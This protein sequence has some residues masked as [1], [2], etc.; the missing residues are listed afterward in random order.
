[1]VGD[2]VQLVDDEDLAGGIDDDTGVH[3][4]HQVR[5]RDNLEKRRVQAAD[6]PGFLVEEL[7]RPG[8]WEKT[9]RALRREGVTQYY[10]VGAGQAL[11]KFK[12]WIDIEL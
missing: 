4:E 12:R 5:L 3:V 1:V 2:R 7:C 8:F 6:I 9:C 11:T 10:E